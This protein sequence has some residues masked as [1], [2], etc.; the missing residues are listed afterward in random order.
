MFLLI[1]LLILVLVVTGCG[2][3]GYGAG[4][5]ADCFA[6]LGDLPS[7]LRGVAALAGAVAAAVYAWGLLHVGGAVLDAED[8]G[9][10]SS[11]ILPCRSDE[12]A[13]HVTDYSVSFIPLD[14]VCETNDGDSYP[15]DDVPAY[16]TPVAVGLA[17]AAA[18]CAVSSGYVTELRARRE[19]T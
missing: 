10:N 12:R 5:T 13:A 11:P 8:G 18:G 15:T 6:R 9:A 7:G 19:R 16:I 4:R 1:P 17:L 3:L 14:F 2:L